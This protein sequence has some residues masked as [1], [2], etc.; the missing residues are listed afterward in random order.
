MSVPLS[1]IKSAL[2]IDYDDDDADLIRLREAAFAMVERRTG[3]AL[4][5]RTDTLYLS[6]FSDTVIP[7]F[8]FGA[9]SSVSYTDPNGTAVTMPAASYW[10]DLSDGPM[11]VLRFLDWPAIKEGTMVSCAYSCG[12]DMLP[13]PLTHCVIALV[14]AWYNNPEAFQPIGLNVVPM[15]VEFI[16]DTYQARSP[17]R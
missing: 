1:T 13:D 16:L 12:H 5:Q 2:R 4:T 14:G 7:G 9:V 3:R 6:T 10:I 8:P 15:S 11:P 17:L